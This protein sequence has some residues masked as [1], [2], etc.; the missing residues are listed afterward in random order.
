L[1]HHP[2]DLNQAFEQYER[3]QRPHVTR[4]QATAAPGGDL[5]IPATQEDIDARN[6]RLNAKKSGIV[7]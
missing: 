1:H 2:D 3:D 6:R 5:L 7:G 4:S